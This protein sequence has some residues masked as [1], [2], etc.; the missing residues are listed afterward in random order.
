MLNFA[1]DNIEINRFC[2]FK[3]YSLKTLRKIFTLDEINYCL[4]IKPKINERFAARFC[5]K[6]AAYK[7]INIF[8]EKNISL[9][10]FCKYI[11]IQKEI[12]GNPI[13]NIDFGKLRLKNNIKI[14]KILLS[15]T[16]TKSIAMAFV[17]IF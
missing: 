5:A 17:A 7:A 9:I 3:N 2:N 6:E 15:I 8:L 1:V 16:H 12:S 11:E 13:I 10:E 14:D 4:K